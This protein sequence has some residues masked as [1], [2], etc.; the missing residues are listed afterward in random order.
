MVERRIDAED[1]QDET[2]VLG[3]T[4]GS[5]PDDDDD[6]ETRHI[7]VPLGSRTAVMP[8]KEEPTQKMRRRPNPAAAA[9]TQPMRNRG[10]ENP[11]SAPSPISLADTQSRP[12]EV[13]AYDQRYEPRSVL[14]VGGMGE[15]RL[16]KDR[17]IGR[18]VALKVMRA[19]TTAGTEAR[20][21]FVR[22]ARIQGQLEHPA[23]VPV[24]DLGVDP[25][26]G[27]FFTMKR[28]R[29]M[30]LH[31][32]LYALADRD[33]ATRSKYSRRKLLTAFGSVCLAVD[34]AHQRGVL[35]RDLKPAN[36]IL[37]DYGEVYLIDWGLAKA[38][39]VTRAVQP[40]AVELAPDA[41]DHTMHGSLLGTP[42]YMSPEQARGEIDRLDARSDIYA[43]GAILFEILAG[44]PLHL[45]TAPEAL[46]LATLRGRDARPSARGCIDVPPE[47]D[48]VCARATELD[49]ARRYQTARALSDAIERFLDGDRNVQLRRDLAKS[50]VSSA[51]EALD[52]A[53]GGGEE[54]HEL[55]AL[56][57][58]EVGL[59][60]ALDP[61]NAA[62]L[63]T[64]A[65]LLMDVPAEVPREAQ[66]ELQAAAATARRD[67]ARVG[68]NRFLMWS[69][70]LPLAL[71]MGVRHIPSTAATIA[72]VVLCG[73]TSW[74]LSRRASV[75]LRQGF[76]LLLLSSIAI[77]LMGALF[78][79]FIL[80]PGL[81]ATNTMFFAM[82]ADKPQRR[83]VVVLGVLSIALP[84]FLEIGGV[85]PPSYQYQDG[86]L[87][88]LPRAANFPAM[89]TTLCL[90]LLSTAMVLI[91]G[92]L[93]GRMR[94][95]LT[96]AER[97]VFM[98]AW[99][100]RQLVPSEAHEALSVRR[101]QGLKNA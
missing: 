61:S 71:W 49:P 72:A 33:A 21:R 64:M 88:V 63:K 35:H 12:V 53:A 70:F 26:G 38:G 28:I 16:C 85:V 101:P 54:A 37:G 41:M 50:H 62:A 78:G 98:Q 31:S 48:A 47:L 57:M 43:L 51:H 4:A 27:V 24:Y 81:A 29:G 74:W 73:V 100:L 79:P 65:H 30:T 89:Q 87:Q 90:F 84:F 45:E 11:A 8:Q 96:A 60:L 95:A 19:G 80:V 86:L 55:R 1:T 40:E 52:R 5:N 23:I 83:V 14:G 17:M 7:R 97:R 82:N 67:A 6:V 91:P 36:I 69:A 15:V 66:A 18:E 44:E 99:H 32:V 34:F 68:A 46:I 25:K 39:V 13:S 10:F 42:G 93:V 76:A 92:V 58:R 20:D 59:A 56:A 77:G 75:G 3:N 9:P 22:E 2:L 94:D